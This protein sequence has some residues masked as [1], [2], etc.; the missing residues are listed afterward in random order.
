MAGPCSPRYRCCATVFAGTGPN[1]FAN[2]FLSDSW[3]PGIQGRY[4]WFQCIV[5]HKYIEY[6]VYGDLM[7][8]MIYLKPD[9][10]YLRGA[11]V[12][13]EPS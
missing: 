5:P 8:L 2:K 7:F 10:I 12:C 13:N 4:S 6:G 3:G 11:I 9:S 1:I